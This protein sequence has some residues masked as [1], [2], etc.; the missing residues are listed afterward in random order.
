MD[1]V[2]RFLSFGNEFASCRND[3]ATASYAVSDLWAQ[4]QQKLKYA[5]RFGGDVQQAA[6]QNARMRMNLVTPFRREGGRQSSRCA[7]GSL[8]SGL[9]RTFWEV[10]AGVVPSQ[11]PLHLPFRAKRRCTCAESFNEFCCPCY[12]CGARAASHP[13]RNAGEVKERTLDRGSHRRSR[14]D[15][16]GQSSLHSHG[17]DRCSTWHVDRAVSAREEVGPVAG[18]P[19]TYPPCLANSS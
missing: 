18:Y 7:L 6:T 1:W 11:S 14:R 10:I 19:H 3:V 9:N 4:G 16:L 17:L 15:G 2:C 5:V 8:A 13:R 12:W